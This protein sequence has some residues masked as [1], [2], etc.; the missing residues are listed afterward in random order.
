MCN[1]IIV[2]GI[3]GSGKSTYVSKV[4]KP[5]L[6]Y[7]KIYKYDN[8]TLLYNK[9]DIFLKN[10][11]SSAYLDAYNKELISYIKTQDPD[12]TFEAIFMYTDI[13][14]YYEILA[15]GKDRNFAE[16]SRTDITYDEYIE[17]IINGIKY[18]NN[19]T[20]NIISKITYKYRTVDNTYIDSDNDTHLTEMLN[21]SK[22][23][24]LL[25][26]INTISGHSTY[27]SIMIR[28]ECVKKGTE[29]DWITFDN[30]LK[31]TS[32]KDKVIYD[33]GCFNGYFSFRC[34]KEG[35][36]KI[37]GV[38]HNTPAINICN[39]L[40]LYNNYHL[41]NLGKMVDISCKGGIS[42]NVRKIG[43]DNIFDISDDKIDV[44]FA[45]NFLHHLKNEL[46]L[47][48]FLSVVDSFFKNAN[49]IIFEVNEA[50]IEY[51]NNISVNNKFTLATKIESHRKTMF[52]NRWVLHFKKID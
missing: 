48:V 5:V 23:D 22:K 50:E 41:W 49:E 47:E 32:L 20:K 34:V 45:L 42:F 18:L 4:D 1:Y 38:D 16:S 9:I 14:K 19:Y 33:A 6:H 46:G 13:D 40:C 51:I 26:Y 29:G 37:I 30:I 2:T 11:Y 27:Q 21:I 15:A 17:K 31:C 12:A 28:D 35:A 36:K 3:S 7:D 24:R 25:K 52:G 43:K 39:K 8:S 10:N 44:I